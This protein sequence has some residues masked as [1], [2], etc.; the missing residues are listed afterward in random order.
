M[1]KWDVFYISFGCLLIMLSYTTSTPIP[2]VVSGFAV[3]LLGVFRIYK[4]KKR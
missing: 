2:I 3:A 1:N 4:G